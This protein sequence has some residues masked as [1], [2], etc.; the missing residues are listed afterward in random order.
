MGHNQSCLHHLSESNINNGRGIFNRVAG[1]QINNVA[2]HLNS[3]AGRFALGRE[4]RLADSVQLAEPFQGAV[5]SLLE[6]KQLLDELAVAFPATS[7]VCLL[8]KE[9]DDFLPVVICV[10]LAMAFINDTSPQLSSNSYFHTF[11]AVA[12]EYRR[13]LEQMPA[14]IRGYQTHIADYL[15]ASCLRQIFLT[16]FATYRWRPWLQ[17]VLSYIRRDSATSKVLLKSLLTYVTSSL[18]DSS[19]TST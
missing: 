19:L 3:V 6:V 17:A 14:D 5:N 4:R 9:V 12:F 2:V 16:I 7:S 13:Y 8:R 10:A 15:D 11:T 18:L 1:N